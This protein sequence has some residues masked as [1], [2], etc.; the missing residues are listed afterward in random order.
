MDRTRTV[1]IIGVGLIGGSIGLALRERGR[2]GRVVGIGRDRARLE[3]ARE[4]GA[5]DAW[6]TDAAEGVAGAEVAVVCT[7][8]TRIVEDILHAA[9]HGPASILVTDAGSTKARIVA[10]VEAD[11][12]GRAAFVG[13]HPVAGSERQGAA[14]ARADLFEGRSCVLTPTAST[15]PDRLARARDFWAGLGCR[16]FEVDPVTHDDRLALTSHLPHAVASALA[17]SVPPELFPLA[18]GAYRDGTRVAGADAALWAGIFRENRGPLL[19]ALAGFDAHLARFRAALQADSAEE[20]VA[21][22]EIGREHRLRFPPS[23]PLP[24]CN[25]DAKFS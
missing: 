7:P 1:A 9:G 21:W 11:P 25:P 15:P 2:A 18:A 22:W 8:V 10:G 4:L 6:T 5:V 24:V 13:A 14:H 17:A 12:R 16:V 3:E 20:L 23:G 19:E